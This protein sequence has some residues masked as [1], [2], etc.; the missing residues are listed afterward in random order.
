[1]LDRLTGP[2]PS[3][4][5]VIAEESW[6]D[7]SIHTEFGVARAYFA[8]EE[9][10]AI[11]RFFEWISEPGAADSPN[12]VCPRDFGILLEETETGRLGHV[13]MADQDSDGEHATAVFVD[14]STA[15]QLA[16]QLFECAAE[17]AAFWIGDDED[18]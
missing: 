9:A 14:A 18:D 12:N 10:Y 5:L 11:A 17:A 2:A 1:M 15:E 6:V 13:V 8:P 3:Q 7:L 16:V 4:I